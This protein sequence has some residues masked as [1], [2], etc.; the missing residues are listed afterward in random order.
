MLLDCDEIPT[1]L[2][3]A[4]AISVMAIDKQRYELHVGLRGDSKRRF[5]SLP[6]EISVSLSPAMPLGYSSGR[7]ERDADS[8]IGESCS[9]KSMG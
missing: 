8:R 4:E 3:R 9:F 5:V 6:L 7:V 1:S 2:R